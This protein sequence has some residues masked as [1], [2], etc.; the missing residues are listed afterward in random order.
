MKRAVVIVAVL[1]NAIAA[2]GTAVPLSSE[3]CAELIRAAGKAPPKSIDIT[4]WVTVRDYTRTEA[5]FRRLYEQAYTEM[6][7]ADEDLKGD[8]LERR[9]EFVQMNVERVV[10]E[11]QEGG[12]RV[13][14]RIRFDGNRQRIEKSNATTP[15]LPKTAAVDA[16]AFYETSIIEVTGPNDVSERYVYSHSG[17]GATRQIVRRREPFEDSKIMEFVQMPA[18][19]LLRRELGVHEEGTRPGATWIVDPQKREQ[20]GTGMVGSMRVTIQPD[21]NAP[22]ERERIE[23]RWTNDRSKSHAR[24]IMVCAKGDYSRVYQYESRIGETGPIGQTRTCRDFD[25]QGFPHHV[26]MTEYDGQGKVRLQEDYQ[27]EKVSL[28]TPIPDAVFQFAPPKGYVVTDFRVTPADPKAMEIAQLK[29]RLTHE[30]AADRLQALNMLAKELQDKPEEL[31]AILTALKDDAYPQ[32][33][34]TAT[35]ILQHMEGNEEE[36]K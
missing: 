25:A 18:A 10:K 20:L 15:A 2:A 30:Q 23:L 33:R 32:I 3:Q 13:K 34:A 12:R 4:Y 16:N 7:G 28:N 24:S 8:A 11:Q 31:R 26:T 29:E 14:Y 21:S 5:D 27:I 35:F 19:R 36:K 17:R 6:H 22:N 1:W 9:N